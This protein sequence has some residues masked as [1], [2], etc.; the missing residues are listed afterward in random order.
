M[1][2]IEDQTEANKYKKSW[3]SICRFCEAKTKV[4]DVLTKHRLYPLKILWTLIMSLKASG[5]CPLGSNI[6]FSAPGKKRLEDSRRHSSHA[7]PPQL[8]NTTKTHPKKQDPTFKKLIWCNQKEYFWVECQFL[9]HQTGPP[10]F[11]CSFRDTGS[12][13]T[14]EWLSAE[15]SVSKTGGLSHFV[16]ALIDGCWPKYLLAGETAGE[17]ELSCTDEEG[18]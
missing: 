11:A 13:I 12:E 3:R 8:C 14:P 7:P 6:A 2:P 15:W 17:N 18:G 10:G 5:A 9:S 1:A 16:C 4:R